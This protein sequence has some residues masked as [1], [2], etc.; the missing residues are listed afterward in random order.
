MLPL[1]WYVLCLHNRLIAYADDLKILAKKYI[2][3][4]VDIWSMGVVLYSMVCGRFPFGNVSNIIEGQFEMPSH[5]NPGSPS[6]GSTE[7]SSLTFLL[8]A[9]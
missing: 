4:E 9:G 5:L 8:S 3:P 7:Y 6:L 1:K 2:G